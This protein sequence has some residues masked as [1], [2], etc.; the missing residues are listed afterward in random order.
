M[1]ETLNIEGETEKNIY[2]KR[3]FKWVI[4]IVNGRGVD[5]LEMFSLNEAECNKMISDAVYSM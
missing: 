4:Y 3:V 2:I 1:C 5:K